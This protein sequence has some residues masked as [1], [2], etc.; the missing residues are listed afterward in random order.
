MARYH[1]WHRKR[2]AGPQGMTGLWQVSGRS[3]LSFEEM[4]LLDIYYLENWTLLL[5]LEIILKTVP[6]ILMGRGAY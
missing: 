1:P 6:V 4:V 2:Y 5:D 3:E